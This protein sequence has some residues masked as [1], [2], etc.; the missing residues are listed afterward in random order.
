MTEQSEHSQLNGIDV[1]KARLTTAPGSLEPA[2][3]ASEELQYVPKWISMDYIRASSGLDKPQCKLIQ[4]M[5]SSETEVLAP[6][7]KA[8]FPAGK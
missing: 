1:S 7:V 5:A 2:D 4:P 8:L 3:R 6:L